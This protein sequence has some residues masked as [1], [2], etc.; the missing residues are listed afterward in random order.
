[1]TTVPHNGL[2]ASSRCKSSKIG[3][4]KPIAIY[5]ICLCVRD[6]LDIK[7]FLGRSLY[8]GSSSSSQTQTSL[9]KDI[10]L[11]IG[12]LQL[13]EAQ[14]L[15][16]ADDVP[17]EDLNTLGPPSKGPRRRFKTFLDLPKQDT[18]AFA[19]FRTNFCWED[20]EDQARRLVETVPYIANARYSLVP[21]RCFL[22]LSFDSD[23]HRISEDDFWMFFFFGLNLFLKESKSR[24]QTS[25][26]A[27]ISTSET[28]I[29]IE[30]KEAAEDLAVF[31]HVLIKVRLCFIYAI[32][33]KQSTTIA[34]GHYAQQWDL[35]SP[36]FTGCVIVL[37]NKQDELKI[38]IRHREDE[39]QVFAESFIIPAT[40]IASG[41]QELKFFVE[42]VVDS[43]RYFV[44]KIQDHVSG[45]KGIV[46]LGFKDRNESFDFQA[47]I[48]DFIKMVRRQYIAKT[49]AESIP[50]EPDAPDSTDNARPPSTGVYRLDEASI[51]KTPEASTNPKLKQK[52]KPKDSDVIIPSL[53]PPPTEDEWTEFKAQ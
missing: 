15:S 16:S 44:M 42:P 6:T 33:N 38:S 21:S 18:L 31:S 36:I 23:S 47:S 27:Q 50:L 28:K 14:E 3:R 45:K 10:G 49:P 2:E 12:H 25:S 20:F 26:D 4:S 8:M 17:D 34:F 46:G 48:L 7:R 40:D 41:K 13:Q 32:P 24:E 9:E 35:P 1:M 22:L 37:A 30:I 5:D 39:S 52:K 43:S 29:S 19:T 51:L 11:Y 53:S